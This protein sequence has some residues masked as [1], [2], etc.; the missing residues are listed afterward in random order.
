MGIC[1]STIHPKCLWCEKSLSYKGPLILYSFQGCGKY[2][3][4]IMCNLCLSDKIGSNLNSEYDIDLS[5]GSN[6]GPS[7]M[8]IYAKKLNKRLT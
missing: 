1:F 2:H 7:G 6:D 4:K 8:K 3:K 5:T